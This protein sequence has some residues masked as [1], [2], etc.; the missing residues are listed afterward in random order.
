MPMPPNVNAAFEEATPIVNAALASALANPLYAAQSK[1]LVTEL[2]IPDTKLNFRFL[3]DNRGLKKLTK[4]IEKKAA[5]EKEITIFSDEYTDNITVALRDLKSTH[6]DK[7]RMMGE[8]LGQGVGPW[9]DQKV[10]S[11]L[12]AGGGMFVTPSFDDVPYFSTAH[13][14]DLA[15]EDIATYSN[16]DSGGASALWYIFDTR[17]MTPI[18]LNWAERPKNIDLG[19][20]SEHAKKAFEV[21]W[22]LYADAGFGATLWQYGYASNRALTEEFFNAARVAMEAVP[23]YAKADDG[24]QIMGVMPTL[25]VVGR[26]N[27]LAAERLIKSATVDGDPNPLYGTTELLVLSYLP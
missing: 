12:K 21:M 11:L 1:P 19:P 8:Q 22:T 4:N 10:A 9:Q 3:L 24:S 17:R 6:G 25:L 18:W 13:P 27:R 16:Y 23:T 14:M 7:Y 5:V 15:G 2:G 26:S 20:D